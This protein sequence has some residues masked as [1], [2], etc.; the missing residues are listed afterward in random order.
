[1]NS[2]CTLTV[3]LSI[4]IELALSVSALSL[5]PSSDS[6]V[7]FTVDLGSGISVSTAATS[8]DI[9][10]LQPTQAVLVVAQYPPSSAGTRIAAVPL[11]GGRITGSAKQLVVDAN[12]TVQFQFQAGSDSGLYQ[13]SLR[14]RNKEVALSFWVLDSESPSNNPVLVN[15]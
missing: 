5:S 7:V 1:M 8:D 14:D 3:L 9:V 12:G 6:D 15:Q 4:A 13:I 11:D 2:R 10:G